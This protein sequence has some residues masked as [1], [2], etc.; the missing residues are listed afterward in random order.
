MKFT[1]L[2]IFILSLASCNQS[3]SSNKISEITLNEEVSELF[4]NSPIVISDSVSYYSNACNDPSFQF[5]I[6]VNINNDKFIDFFAH[7][8]CDTTTPAEIETK[9]VPDI[10]IAYVSDNNGNYS[11]DNLG[12]F[13]ELYPKLGGAS[14]KYARGDINGDGKAD[15]L[16]TYPGSDTSTGGK[17]WGKLMNDVDSCFKCDVRHKKNQ[18]GKCEEC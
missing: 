7:F 16:C 2:V 11:V 8:W 9:D 3:T 18:E 15:M 12:V 5:L 4:N 13:N 6:P 1:L 14:R 17:H 10:L